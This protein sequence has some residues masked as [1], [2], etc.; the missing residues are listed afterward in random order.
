MFQYVCLFHTCIL[1]ISS[2]IFFL[3]PFLTGSGG[4]KRD[5]VIQHELLLSASDTESEIFQHLSSDLRMCCVMRYSFFN[6]LGFHLLFEESA[7]AG[8]AG[9]RE[10]TRMIDKL[11]IYF[12]QALTII[13]RM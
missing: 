3:H 8:R 11:Y 9:R 6:D 13:D 4:P 7:L 2:H 1:K 12:T 5:T 10:A